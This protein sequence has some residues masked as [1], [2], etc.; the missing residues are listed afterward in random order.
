[1]AWSSSG[2]TATCGCLCT[3]W[4]HVFAKQTSWCRQ[5]DAICCW[6]LSW[7]TYVMPT[8]GLCC[9]CTLSSDM[10]VML[11]TKKAEWQQ[12]ST[13]ISAMYSTPIGVVT[14]LQ[15]W[16]PAQLAGRT[17]CPDHELA[18]E[19]DCRQHQAAFWQTR[20]PFVAHAPIHHSHYSHLWV[21]FSCT[22]IKDKCKK[23]SLSYR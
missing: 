21:C 10:Y 12:K 23:S 13:S 1:M 18:V 17:V 3:V 22:V 6:M 16:K 11:F 2:S 9:N 5:H 7:V 4:H 20:C 15:S 8:S 14:C 19:Y